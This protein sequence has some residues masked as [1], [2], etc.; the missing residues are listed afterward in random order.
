VAFKISR[1]KNAEKGPDSTAG[2]AG[3]GKGAVVPIAG[4]GGGG[5][6]DGGSGSGSDEVPWVLLLPPADR[7]R[8]TEGSTGSAAGVGGVGDEGGCAQKMLGT[9]LVRRQSASGPNKAPTKGLCIR[10]STAAGVSTVPCWEESFEE[11]QRPDVHELSLSTYDLV[12]RTH[13]VPVNIR[14]SP[15]ASTPAL[16]SNE[17]LATASSCF[18]AFAGVMSSP[19]VR[20]CGG[21][22]IVT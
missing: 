19:A 13:H 5:D 4:G 14:D 17:D 1:S 11:V 15:A 9:G 20:W 10:P 16:D 8:G 6:G 21:S 12:D 18:A 2:G 22:D 7:Q 3:G